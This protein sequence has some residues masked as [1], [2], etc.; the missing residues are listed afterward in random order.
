M[1]EP[2][3]E[4]R[5]TPVEYAVYGVLCAAKRETGPQGM[6]RMYRIQGRIDNWD[7]WEVA[8]ALI[9]LIELGWVVQQPS[10]E[11][12]YVYFEAVATVTVTA[13]PGASG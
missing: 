8:A 10:N 3:P 13:T 6:R 9:R 7:D 4:I 2:D 1:A 5:L 12:G 11:F